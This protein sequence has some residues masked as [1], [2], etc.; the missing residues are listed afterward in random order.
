VDLGAGS[1]RQA[2]SCPVGMVLALERHG[3]FRG[4]HT[5]YSVATVTWAG[6]LLWGN[7]SRPGQLPS[8]SVTISCCIRSTEYLA[9]R[10]ASLQLA[11]VNHM[12]LPFWLQ[13]IEELSQ[14]CYMHPRRSHGS[15]KRWRS[16]KSANFLVGISLSLPSPLP[17]LCINNQ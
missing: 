8:V 2:L 5:P 10:N 14:L 15:Q 6:M 12:L 16:P 17:K 3:D 9:K 13:S 11:Q 4:L 7:R 1:C